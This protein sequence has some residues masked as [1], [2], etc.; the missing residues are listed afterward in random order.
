M[1]DWLI[2]FSNIAA[3][4]VRTIIGLF[5]IYRLLATQ[6]PGRNRVIIAADG[7]IVISAILSVTGLSDFYRM[8]LEIAW[9]T[10]CSSYRI[11]QQI[12]KS[13]SHWV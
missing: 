9:I 11:S 1:T 10:V 12:G 7:I 5:L 13:F 3:G 2:L 6:K 4:S 8:V